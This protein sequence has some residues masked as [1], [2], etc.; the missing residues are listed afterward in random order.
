MEPAYHQLEFDLRLYLTHLD[1]GGERLW[2]S[3]AVL[4]PS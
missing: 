1:S 2:P 3:A 4:P